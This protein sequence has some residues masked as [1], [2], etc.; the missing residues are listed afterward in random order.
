MLTVLKNS[1]VIC[2]ALALSLV[3]VECAAQ[4]QQPVFETQS[5]V[6]RA[7]RIPVHKWANT[8]KLTKGVV[9]AV[10]GLVFT[11]KSYNGLAKHLTEKGYIVYSAEMRGYGE[12]LKPDAKFDG[13]KLVH[14]TQSQEDL[15]NVLAAVRKQHAGLPVYCLGESFGANYAVW[16]A[17]THPELLDGVIAGGLSYKICIHPRARWFYT[18]AQGCAHP[19]RP[20][21]WI[22]YL[23]PIMSEDKKAS[24]QRLNDPDTFTK[25]SATDMIKAAVSTKRAIREV[26]RI[27][28]TMPVLVVAGE[29]DQIQKTRRLPEFVARFGSKYTRLVVVPRLGHLLF[30]HNNVAPEVTT[31]VDTWLDQQVEKSAVSATTAVSTGSF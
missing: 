14:Y 10:P 19:K 31:I 15:T 7:L 28:S 26:H 9:V 11:A 8:D 3:G 20:I 1:F 12:W 22:S 29:K 18:F 16:Q 4:E 5:D 30:E 23:K 2:A 24:A 27:P 25:L 6:G 13:D 17:S 21:S